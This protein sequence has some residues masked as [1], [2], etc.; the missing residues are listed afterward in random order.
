MKRTD[1]LI[2]PHCSKQVAFEV[3][4]TEWDEDGG[5]YDITGIRKGTKS[6]EKATDR[7][8]IPI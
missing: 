3:E 1:V 4:Q 6:D 5:F 8:A 7:M 2:C